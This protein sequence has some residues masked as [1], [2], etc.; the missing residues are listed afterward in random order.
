VELV[1]VKLFRTYL[2][3]VSERQLLALVSDSVSRG[4]GGKIVTVNLDILRIIESRRSP[5][6]ADLLVLD[7]VPLVLASR[8]A[9]AVGAEKLAGSDL[10]FS[11]TEAMVAISKRILFLGGNPGTASTTVSKM[12]ARYGGERY[13]LHEELFFG[14]EREP[15][16]FNATIDRI[17]NFDPH[18]V[19]VALNF[20]KADRLIDQLRANFPKTW[21]VGVG[22][23]FSY[24]AGEI[25][26]APKWA[27]SLS[28]EWF[29]RL[30]QEPRKLFKRYFIQD[31]P[32]LF[33]LALYLLSA[34]F[35]GKLLIKG[36][37]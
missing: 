11:L 4:I 26:R 9:G 18:L 21:F 32:V 10:I 20:E 13:F 6:I 29:F 15:R 33:N 24:V 35:R 3:I 37:V 22:I 31:F 34:R 25:S 17:M 2:D 19:F 28:L 1:K 12:V 30:C 5:T 23:S 7:G 36:D 8:I 27:Q 14:F 16:R